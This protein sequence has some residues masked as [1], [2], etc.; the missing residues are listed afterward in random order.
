[1]AS[2]SIKACTGPIFEDL[3]DWEVISVAILIGLRSP[4][5]DRLWYYQLVGWNIVAK[6]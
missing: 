5:G 4:P 2:M 3:D 1:M 6:T